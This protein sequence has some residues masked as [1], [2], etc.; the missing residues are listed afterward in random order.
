MEAPAAALRRAAAPIALRVRVVARV[1]ARAVARAA[2][3]AA[4]R[5]VVGHA[6]LARPAAPAVARA[7]A[8]PAARSSPSRRRMAGSARKRGAGLCARAQ[9]APAGC[10]RLAAEGGVCVRVFVS[11]ACWWRL[12]ASSGCAV[13]MMP[14]RNCPAWRVLWAVHG[15]GSA[16]AACAALPCAHVGAC[17][18]CS[19]SAPARAQCAVWQL[20]CGH[21]ARLEVD[22]WEVAWL[23][24]C[25][26]W[27]GGSRCQASAFLMHLVGGADCVTGNHVASDYEL[28]ASGTS[29]YYSTCNVQYM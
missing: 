11:S 26:V 6:A 17:I 21:V 14:R 4:A 25:C 20:A 19:C 22:G 3:R 15:Y 1:V 13:R 28:G 9:R 10:M 12:R 5:A 18:A 29:L 8:A 23:A 24:A 7:R 16:I 2:A 27:G